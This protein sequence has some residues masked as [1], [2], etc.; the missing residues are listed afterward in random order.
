M[1]IE[2]EQCYNCTDSI[3][4]EYFLL[5]P[6]YDFSLITGNSQCNEMVLSLFCNAAMVYD[7]MTTSLDE[8]CVQVRDNECASE[9]RL[10]ETFFDLTLLNCSSLNK[11]ESISLSRAPTQSC[12][13]HFGVL[14]GSICLP[15][16]AEFS[17]FNDGTTIAYEVLNIICHSVSIIAGFIALVACIYHRKKM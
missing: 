9:W 8:M 7:D 17:L 2:S 16:C 14:C 12:P 11:S 3:A 15:L 10:V 13:D 5:Q 1:C 4:Q 6:V